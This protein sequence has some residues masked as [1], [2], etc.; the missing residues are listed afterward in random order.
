MASTSQRSLLLIALISLFAISAT[1]SRP[2]KTLFV[3]SYSFSLRRLPSS[4]SSS[5]FVTIVTEISHIRPVHLHPT[6]FDD[7][8]VPH[9]HHHDASEKRTSA[10][11][12]LLP[13]EPAPPAPRSPP[14]LFHVCFNPR[15]R[16]LRRGDRPRVVT[17]TTAGESATTGES[18]SLRRRSWV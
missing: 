7:G 15:P 11:I 9:P 14:S 10:P 18:A 3:S 13:T 5:G 6:R 8:F 2:C 4:S 1:A 17:S 16:L 12:L